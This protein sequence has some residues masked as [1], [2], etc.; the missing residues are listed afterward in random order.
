M[1]KP[2]LIVTRRLPPTVERRI[3]KNYRALLNPDDVQ[4]GSESLLR[5][6]SSADGILCT[7]TER[8]DRT[9][10]DRLPNRLR[11]IATFSV[12]YDHIEVAAAQRRGITVTNTPDVL[13]EATADVALL[14]LLGAS[15]RAY[16]GNRLVRERTWG[17][18]SAVDF[19]GVGLQGKTLG[20]LGLGR[21]GRATARRAVAC[22]LSVIYHNRTPVAEASTI[23]A[24]YVA[25]LDAFLARAQF[26]SLH[27]PAT[28]ATRHFLNA[29]NLAKLPKGAI[30]VNTARGALVND[31]ALIAALKSGQVA[32]VGLDVYEG[33]PAVNPGYLELA[34]TFLLPHLG[35]ATIE[36]RDAMGHRAVDNIDAFFAGRTPGD[37]VAA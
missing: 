22:G 16:E 24:E 19:L 29:A 14:C 20:I 32:A 7:T 30:V 31:E 6:A 15:R 5:V 2:V 10:I 28:P 25:R 11:I 17:R 13:T 35:S 4:F 36:T 18:W 3:E 8:I 1:A 26:L 33:E 34:N 23:P 12:G 27:V 21:I 9:L 37:I